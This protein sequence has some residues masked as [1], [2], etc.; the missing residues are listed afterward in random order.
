VEDGPARQQSG[1]TNQAISWLNL[2]DR[3]WSLRLKK[4]VIAPPGAPQW[5][6][7]YICLASRERC[8]RLCQKDAARRRCHVFI[9]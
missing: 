6:K 8:Q 4:N 1:I 2:A 7:V 3:F 9:P 5:H